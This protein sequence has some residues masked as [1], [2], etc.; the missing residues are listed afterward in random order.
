MERK[1]FLGRI[2]LAFIIA[3]ILFTSGF[4]M[5]YLISSYQYRAISAS[6]ERLR[7]NLLE[8]DIQKKL[9][10]CEK[11]DP[12]IF[13]REMDYSGSITEALELR[14]GKEDLKV[15]E[16][17]KIYTLIQ[18]QHFL[19][20]KENIEKCS[21][22]IKTI[23]FFYSNKDTY[24]KNAEEIGMMISSI[25]KQNEIMVYSFDFDLDSSTLDLIKNK[26]NVSQPNT[27]IINEE[28]KIENIQN[29]EEIKRNI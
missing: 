11:F 12:Y 8:L 28:V 14:F 2:I 27:I 10:D 29:V 25:K 6:Q 7:Y 15:I 17:K 1:L 26:Y 20:I 19:I 22:D 16:Q 4:F 24:V 9:I 21:L 13:A 18:A 23:L 3:T 5:S